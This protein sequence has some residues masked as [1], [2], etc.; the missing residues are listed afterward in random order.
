MSVH[1]ILNHLG[2]NVKHIADG[3]AVAAAF[4]TLVQFLPPLA[5]LL[6]IVWMSLRIYDW[7]EARFSGGRLPRD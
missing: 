6:T 4:G 7:L 5:S 1:T 3:L 2:D